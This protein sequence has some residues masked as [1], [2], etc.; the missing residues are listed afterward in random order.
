MS[1]LIAEG[2]GHTSL[3]A[4]ILQNPTRHIDYKIT[5]YRSYVRQIEGSLRFGNRSYV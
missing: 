3:N 4:T 5:A 1:S 2:L